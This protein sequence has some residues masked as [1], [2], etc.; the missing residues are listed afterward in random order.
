MSGTNESKEASVELMRDMG[1]TVSQ[2]VS[3]APVAKLDLAQVT[4]DMEQRVALVERI[5][6]IIQKQINP[7]TDIVKM[8]NKFRRTINFA[9][10]CYRMVGGS[11]EYQTYANGL[12][13]FRE[14]MQDEQGPW[15]AVTVS[16]VY[17]TPW[18][19]K[20]EAFKRMTSREDFLGV[21]G[22]EYREASDVC[23]TDI[24]EM[25]VTEAFKTVVF[26]ALGLPKDIS[27]SE[28]S[29]FGVQSA[30]ASGHTFAG[31]QGAQG[32]NKAESQETYDMRKDLAKMCADLVACGYERDGE[33]ATTADTMLLMVTK[34]PPSWK[35]WS[36][37]KNV[38]EKALGRTHADVKKVWEAEMKKQG[39][40]GVRDDLGWPEE[41]GANG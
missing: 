8:G 38:S 39:G 37:I 4:K 32:G 25:A 31:A 35:G 34:N 27:A 10:K 41:P 40:A 33:Q 11:I 28:L 36:A 19:E 1:V 12:K 29:K 26:T 15:F 13:Y 3:V 23:E 24:V 7:E 5:H 30:G 20:V 6:A 2:G 22:G 16:C 9:R 17:S 21:T 14:S 18:G